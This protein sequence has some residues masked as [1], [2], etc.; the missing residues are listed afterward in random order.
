MWVLCQTLCALCPFAF[1]LLT[2]VCGRNP[3]S[4]GLLLQSFC[5]VQPVS[6]LLLLPCL[7]A[8]PP[9]PDSYAGSILNRTQAFIMARTMPQQLQKRAPS[10]G[11]Y[12]QE[13]NTRTLGSRFGPGFQPSKIL[14]SQIP[15]YLFYHSYLS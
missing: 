5:N 14:N 4:N 7:H 3:S 11:T 6:P 10:L 2:T 1:L 8:G 13:S 9:L 12:D 15:S